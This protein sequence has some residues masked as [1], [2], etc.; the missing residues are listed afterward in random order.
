MAAWASRNRFPPI[1][2]PYDDVAV[3]F[4]CGDVFKRQNPEYG[5]LPLTAIAALVPEGVAA[6]VGV[7]M[8]P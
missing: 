7:V 2:A 6:T 8:L 1:G 4:R 3:H 5:V